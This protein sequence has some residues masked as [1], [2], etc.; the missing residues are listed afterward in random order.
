M[1]GMMIAVQIIDYGKPLEIREAPIPEIRDEE[2]LIKIE[3][4]ELCHSDIPLMDGS[5]T[6]L[7]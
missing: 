1:S 4:S 3:A 7:V 2:V 6:G 5:I